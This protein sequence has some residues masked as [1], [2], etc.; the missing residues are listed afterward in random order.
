MHWN[1]IL[2]IACFSCT[3][4]LA[5]ALRAQSV[6]YF[7]KE[8]LWLL[9]TDHNSYVLAVGPHGELRHLYW[10]PPVQREGDLTSPGP[11]PDISSFDPSQMLIN[12]EYPGWGEPLC[13]RIQEGFTEAYAPKLMSSWV[14][15]VPNMNGRSTPLQ[16]RF[17]V[18]MQGAL[19]IGANL[20]RWSP[21][22][23]ALA[24]KMI[25]LYKRIRPTVQTGD[26]YCLLSPRTSDVTANEYVARDG[27]LAVL[28]AFRHS[29]QYSTPAPTI[30]LRGLDPHALYRLT[31]IDGKLLDK[32]QEL[33]GAY[34]MGAG[35]HLNL[36]GDFDSTAVLLE[37]VQ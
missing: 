14:T 32:Q 23:S 3:L 21:E 19:S 29:R 11:V 24:A 22:D 35:I 8:K 25:T 33:T 31:S 15:D 1:K 30:R 27:N 4:V 16:F 37:R 6:Q 13:L 28:F 17:L 12:E 9:S 7:E 34:L 2:R 18:A 20:N 10:G 36:R 5:G 26:L